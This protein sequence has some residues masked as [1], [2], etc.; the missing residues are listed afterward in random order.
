MTTL[1]YKNNYDDYIMQEQN[2][3]DKYLEM[4]IRYND[5]E[6][7]VYKLRNYNYNNKY[8]E[9]IKL[10]NKIINHI[11]DMYINNYDLFINLTDKQLFRLIKV[12]Y[13]EL[14]KS[15][16]FMDDYINNAV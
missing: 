1:V 4:Y 9:E 16:I 7:I 10:D 12:K 5:L 8:L 15:N 3:T 14:E 2:N 11:I 6:N 13:M